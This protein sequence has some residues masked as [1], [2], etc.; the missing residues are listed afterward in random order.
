MKMIMAT[1]DRKAKKEISH[2]WKQIIVIIFS[3][4]EL[5]PEPNFSAARLM[6]MVAIIWR[7]W[8]ASALIVTSKMTSASVWGLHHL[9]VLGT[10]GLL[11]VQAWLLLLLHGVVP[12]QCCTICTWWIFRPC[13]FLHTSC[14]H[15]YASVCFGP[16]EFDALP[17]L[18]LGI[19]A[20]IFT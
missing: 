5:L 16:S 3:L 12:E 17:P 4:Q 1:T 7:C 10:V 2:V 9:E 20:G 18:L 13:G 14:F 15:S 11:Q 6:M 8:S 19:S